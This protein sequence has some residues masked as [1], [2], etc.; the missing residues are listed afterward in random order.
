MIKRHK[1]SIRREG[2]RFN[3]SVIDLAKG[4]MDLW[5]SAQGTNALGSSPQD[6]KTMTMNSLQS[7]MNRQSLEDSVPCVSANYCYSPQ[8]LHD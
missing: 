5:V 2:A 3:T 1:V 4:L 6:K 8:E 7:S